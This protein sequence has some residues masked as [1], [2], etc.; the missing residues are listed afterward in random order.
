MSLAL[1]VILPF[2]GSLIAAVLPATARNAES[3][4][5]G[6]IAQCPLVDGLA[7]M[8]NVPIGRSL[9]LTAMA[10]A[11]KLGAAIGR[12]PI[13]VP[14]SV[15]PGSFG[16]IATN[17]AITGLERLA[18][19]VPD[20]WP[21]RITARSVLDITRHRPVRRADQASARCSSS[22][23]RRTPWPSWPQPSGAPSARPGE[24]STAA[25]E[26]ITTSTRAAGTTGRSS[27][28]RRPS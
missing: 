21:N 23:R 16:L 17:D 24:S 2:V 7:G 19:D 9:R 3:T 14:V 18:P 10:L 12:R 26:A 27:T 28:W 4:L 15:P 13:Y 6:A 1:L 25:A 22:S 8:R 20:E 5:A 11:D